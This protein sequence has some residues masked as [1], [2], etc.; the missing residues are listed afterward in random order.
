M[1]FRDPADKQP[2]AQNENDL[3]HQLWFHTSTQPDWP[4]S[5]WDPTV[6]WN[7]ESF[8]RMEKMCGAGSVERWRAKQIMKC[9]HVGTLTAALENMDRRR[10]NQADNDSVFWLYRVKL[11]PQAV[12]RAD[13]ISDPGGMVGDV[14]PDEVMRPAESVVKYTN[15]HEDR[16]SVSLA[17]RQ[18]AIAAVQ[19]VPVSV[20]Y[21]EA[22]LLAA[23][24]AAEW[25]DRSV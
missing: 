16:G 18:S 23:L 17:L 19:R 3:L 21:D 15:D 5:S 8:E 22:A 1:S 9:L 13:E 24:D 6:G 4:S 7:A 2:A 25:E 10:R 12:V 14:W 11:S 20:D